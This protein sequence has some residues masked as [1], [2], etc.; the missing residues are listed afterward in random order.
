MPLGQVSRY[1]RM[2]DIHPGGGVVIPI[3]AG[4]SFVKTIEDV[5]VRVE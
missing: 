3:R 4:P 1:P 2:H 5:Q